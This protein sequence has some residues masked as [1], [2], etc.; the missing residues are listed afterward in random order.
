MIWCVPTAIGR[1]VSAVAVDD[2]NLSTPSRY[3]CVATTGYP[4]EEVP[5]ARTD[6]D[7][8]EVNVG[9]VIVTN[10]GFTTTVELVLDEA[11]ILS[12]TVAFTVYVPPVLYR[13]VALTAETEE[14]KPKEMTVLVIV[15]SESIEL[16]ADA[17]MDPPAR[18]DP[19]LKVSAATG[20]LLIVTESCL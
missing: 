5:V 1:V 16:D 14:P 8:V 12:V 20:G 18:I 11:P 15:P 13:C 4:D 2:W 9:L 3:T 17:V 6:V 19:E 10:G 7:V